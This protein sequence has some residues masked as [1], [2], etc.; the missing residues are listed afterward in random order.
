MAG[1]LPRRIIKETQ[2]LMADPVPGISA[3]PDDN[4]ARYE[5]GFSRISFEKH[6]KIS[7]IFPRDDRWTTRFAVRRRCVQAGTVFT[8]GVSD[9]R[10]KGS[11]VTYTF[12]RSFLG[13]GVLE[14]NFLVSEHFLAPV[15][16]CSVFC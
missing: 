10:A 5:Y 12:L 6:S 13:I 14:V 11:F 9:G 15:L 8:R 7:Q 4:N 3:S 16:P 1:A 2:R